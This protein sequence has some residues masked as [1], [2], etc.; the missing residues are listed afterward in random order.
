M[1]YIIILFIELFIIIKFI[2]V[3]TVWFNKIIYYT[4]VIIVIFII[5]FLF[6]YL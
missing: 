3:Q 1:L 2:L 6:L 5:E 4:H